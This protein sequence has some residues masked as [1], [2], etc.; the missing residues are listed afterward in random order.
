MADYYTQFPMN[1]FLEWEYELYLRVLGVPLEQFNRDQGTYELAVKRKLP[2]T[3]DDFR[4]RVGAPHPDKER[5]SKYVWEENVVKP[6]DDV[7]PPEV[8]TKMWN[9]IVKQ[10][11]TKEIDRPSFEEVKAAYKNLYDKAC[12]LDKAGTLHD[13]PTGLDHTALA[14]PEVKE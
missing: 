2:L 14:T 6:G 13:Y 1:P 10:N 9:G 8:V 4:V 3:V 5:G 12:E 7:I 11:A